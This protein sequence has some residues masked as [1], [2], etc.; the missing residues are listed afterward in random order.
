MRLNHYIVLSIK[1]FS[2]IINCMVKKYQQENIFILI[3]ITNIFF[4]IFI[5]L[6]LNMLYFFHLPQKKFENTPIQK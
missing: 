2:Q 3:F 6:R 1:H 4:R 5:T